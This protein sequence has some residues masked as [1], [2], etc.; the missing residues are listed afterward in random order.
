[1]SY[2]QSKITI[3][4]YLNNIPV[5]SKQNLMKSVINT[6]D[7]FCKQ[8]YNKSNQQILDDLSEEIGNTHSNGFYKTKVTLVQ[9]WWQI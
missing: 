1:M 7:T 4:E 6:F 9:E 3:Q 2:L 5:K 8:K